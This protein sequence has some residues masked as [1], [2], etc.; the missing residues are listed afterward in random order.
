MKANNCSMPRTLLQ[1]Q[2]KIIETSKKQCIEREEG[3]VLS[4]RWRSG[5]CSPRACACSSGRSSPTPARPTTTR[6]ELLHACPQRQRELSQ[7]RARSDGR[8]SPTPPSLAPFLIGLPSPVAG[9]LRATGHGGSD[10]SRPTTPPT[11]EGAASHTRLQPKNCGEWRSAPPTSSRPWPA[12][13][14]APCGGEAELLSDSNERPLDLGKC[15]QQHR[16]RGTDELRAWSLGSSSHARAPSRTL[17][18][19]GGDHVPRL[20]NCRGGGAAIVEGA[21]LADRRRRLP[22]HREREKKINDVQ[23]SVVRPVSMGGS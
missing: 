17:G 23:C 10:S 21:P 18:H 6:V 1:H 2:Y 3:F 13:E 14:R 15:V 22:A 5:S 16:L 8:S 20:C 9:E 12:A 11:M 19:G 4:K 7:A